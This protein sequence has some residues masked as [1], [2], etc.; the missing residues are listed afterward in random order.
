MTEASVREEFDLLWQMLETRSG[1]HFRTASTSVQLGDRRFS[2]ALDDVSARHLLIPRTT[3]AD[4]NGL[5]RNGTLS[6]SCINL[7]GEGGVVRTWLAVKCKRFDL[8]DVFMGL[9]ANLVVRLCNSAS[10]RIQDETIEILEEWRALLGS[11]NGADDDVCGLLGELVV[12]K[13]LASANPNRAWKSWEGHRGGRHD[14]RFGRRALEAKTTLRP[15]ARVVSISGLTQLQEPQDGELYIVFI[16]LERVSGGTLSLYK[17]IE[18]LIT[19]GI[20]K[21]DVSELWNEAGFPELD[22]AASRTT[23]EVRETAI[24]N[25]KPGFPRITPAS[26]RSGEAPAGVGNVKYA[27]DLSHGDALP[28]GD[29]D[30]VLKTFL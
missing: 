3:T 12:L 9:A 2:V 26:F 24:Y 28:L 25:V 19:L 21:A 1:A 16:R 15:T 22:D 27:I 11:G 7:R 30:L 6:V 4:V 20:P 18:E 13:L 14:F 8:A 23:Y 10:E 5:W 17:I 29:A